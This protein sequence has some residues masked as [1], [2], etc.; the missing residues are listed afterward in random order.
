MFELFASRLSRCVVAL[1]VF[2]A[3]VAAFSSPASARSH[4]HSAERHAYAHHASRHHH[5]RHHARSSRFERGAAQL[6][7]SGFGN[8]FASYDPNA[9]SGG[10]AMSGGG[11]TTPRV[12]RRMAMSRSGGVAASGEGVAMSSGGFSGG[13]GLVSEARRYVGGNPTG[14]GSLWCARFMNMVLEHTGHRGTGSDMASS[15]ARYGTRVSG[16]QVGAIAVMSRGRGGGHVGIITGVDAQGN[17]IM[18]SGNNGN[19]VREAPISRGRIYA[20]VMPN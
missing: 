9:N 6:Q 13:S 20:Y 8:A 12:S 15:F 4:R 3:A 17:P 1:A 18:I 19:R 7:A 10:I 14:R 2:F 11:G 5:Y 16:P